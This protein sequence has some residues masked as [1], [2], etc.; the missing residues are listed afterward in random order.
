MKTQLTDLNPTTR[1]FPRSRMEAYPLE[2]MSG[3]EYY[4][5][6]PNKNYVVRTLSIL[7]IIAVLIA[8]KVM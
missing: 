6:P 1:C 5:R 3:I 7:G 2:Y 8:I 4:K